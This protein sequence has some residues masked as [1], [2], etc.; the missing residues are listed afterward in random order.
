MAL[1]RQSEAHRI[2]EDAIALDLGDLARQGDALMSHAKAQASTLL[3]QARAQRTTIMQGI[4]Q[5]ARA[6]GLDLGRREGLAL[7]QAS[8]HEQAVKESRSK[9]D[10]LQAAWSKSLADFEKSR[11]AML[12]DAREDVLQLAV[13]LAQRVIKRALDVDPLLVKDQLAAV[14]AMVARP[15]ALTVVVHPEDESLAREALAELASAMDAAKHASLVMDGALSRG[16][17]VVRTSGGGV[18]DASI[19]VQIQRIAEA[20]LPERLS[21]QPSPGSG[22]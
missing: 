11:A 2:A 1:I 10:V 9:L 8:G 13:M 5:Q 16:S 21:K 15:T 7:G 4:E 6:Q 14:L 3:E 20:L 19:D 12:E 18:L 17:C 22:S